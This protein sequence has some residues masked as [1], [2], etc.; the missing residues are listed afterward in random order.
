MIPAVA[1][2]ILSRRAPTLLLLQHCRDPRVATSLA[3]P[4]L[5]QHRQRRAKRLSPT[6][7]DGNGAGQRLCPSA[8]SVEKAERVVRMTV[9]TYF[10]PNKSC[11]PA[12]TRVPQGPN[13]L[14]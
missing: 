3:S 12:K 6:T 7:L 11:R 13:A 8:C 9:E 2:I 10:G 14:N 1:P 4:W 5:T